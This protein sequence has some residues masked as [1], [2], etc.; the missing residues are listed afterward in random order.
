M[1]TGLLIFAVL[2]LVIVG[3]YKTGIRRQSRDEVLGGVCSGL[4]MQFGTTPNLMRVLAVLALFCTGGT[5]VLIYVAL[6]I[7]LPQD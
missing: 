1:L 7:V 2:A 6:W 4:A 3:I 5:A